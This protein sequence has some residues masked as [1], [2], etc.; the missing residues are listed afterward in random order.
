MKA[1][2]TCPVCEHWNN[3]IR[4]KSIDHVLRSMALVKLSDHQYLDHFRI[5]A[6][7][8]NERTRECRE[9]IK[10]GGN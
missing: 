4:N 6:E 5:K 8:N 2:K 3:L 7:I 10:T 9:E 1:Q